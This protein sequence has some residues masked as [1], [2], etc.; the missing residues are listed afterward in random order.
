MTDIYDR[1][2]ATAARLLAPRS[3]GGKGLELTLRRTVPG[4]YDPET[5]TSTDT[6]TDYAGSGLRDSYDLKDV[7]GSLVKSGDVKFLV[8]PLLL[9]GADMP[10]PKTQDKVLFDGDTYN[11]ESVKPWDYAGLAVGFEVQGRK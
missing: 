3:Q 5:G 4:E 1:A 9:N 2:K 7:D 10:E 11:V 6:T 8:S